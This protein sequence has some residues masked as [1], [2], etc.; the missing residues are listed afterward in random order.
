MR[1]ASA[2]VEHSDLISL[3][4]MRLNIIMLMTFKEILILLCDVITEMEVS[5]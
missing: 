1:E 5:Y 3:M 2:R 4:E